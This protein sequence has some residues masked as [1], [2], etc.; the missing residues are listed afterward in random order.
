M[1]CLGK[2]C[3]LLEENVY[4][5]GTNIDI[6]P[7]KDLQGC[8]DVC[9]ITP[10]CVAYSWK[11]DGTCY[12][13]G[14]TWA[15]GSEGFHSAVLGYSFCTKIE[16]DVHYWGNDVGKI[17]NFQKSQTVEDC[18][19]ACRLFKGCKYFTFNPWKECW[20]KSSDSGSSSDKDYVSGSVIF[21]II[22]YY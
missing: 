4:Y 11:I 20:L 8:C 6:I 16:N 17:V 9:T 1:Q 10:G 12:L 13:K 5:E 15:V 7:F 19:V 14:D 2:S 18:C 21:D 22:P 3:G